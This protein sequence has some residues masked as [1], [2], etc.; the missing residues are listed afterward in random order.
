MPYP[1]TSDA[2]LRHQSLDSFVLPVSMLLEASPWVLPRDKD[3][4]GPHL[5]DCPR[6]Y[7]VSVRCGDGPLVSLPCQMPLAPLSD[8]P[9]APRLVVAPY[10]RLRDRIGT[11]QSVF[12]ESGDD[13]VEQ[14][15]QYLQSP[16]ISSLSL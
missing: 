9:A 1:P 14:R 11:I 8:F 4:G 10:E 2:L 3:G 13:L 5:L 15:L 7:C 16:A 12:L 6:Q